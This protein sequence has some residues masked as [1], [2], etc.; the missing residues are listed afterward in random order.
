MREFPATRWSLVIA[1]STGRDGGHAL[2]ELCALYLGPIRSFVRSIAYAARDT[3]DLTQSVFAHIL[4]RHVLA[5]AD[6]QRGRFRGWLKWRI[7][8]VISRER[9]R[10][11]A[12][13]RGGGALVLSLDAAVEDGRHAVE[14]T[15]P[16]TPGRDHACR[17]IAELHQ[18]VTVELERC[19]AARGEH[20]R[21]LRL[22]PFIDGREVPYAALA[23]ECGVAAGTLRKQVFV[24]RKF[25][26]ELVR[27]D[28]QRRG[29]KPADV[30]NEIQSLLAELS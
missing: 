17:Q 4:Q 3:Q 7:L 24:L 10:A 29:V 2:D 22:Q 18:R 12:P 30:D 6:P 13:Q 28:F 26:G 15:D 23:A 27:A 14:P 21:F 8:S 11:R 19:Y 16:R 9:R 5:R 1:A 25:Y 20:E